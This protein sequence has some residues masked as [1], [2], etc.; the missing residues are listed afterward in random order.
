MLAVTAGFQNG[1]SFSIVHETQSRFEEK[2]QTVFSEIKK[3]KRNKQIM[4]EIFHS[5]IMKLIITPLS[6]TPTSFPIQEKF[7]TP[8]DPFPPNFWSVRNYSSV[9]VHLR[10]MRPTPSSD[11]DILKPNGKLKTL[12]TT[13]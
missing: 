12:N 10:G 4:S 11:K 2:D 3:Q 6:Y 7:V 1:F 13:D 9:A 5:M 8:L